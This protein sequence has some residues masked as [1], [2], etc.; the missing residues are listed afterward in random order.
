M[1]DFTVSIPPSLEVPEDFPSLGASSSV[2]GLSSLNINTQMPPIRKYSMS[3]L[4]AADSP[5]TPITPPPQY[6]PAQGDKSTEYHDD[7][8]GWS[9]LPR[10]N[11]IEPDYMDYLS[12]KVKYMLELKSVVCHVGYR[13]DSGHYRSY[14]ADTVSNNGQQLQEPNWLRHDDLD[15]SGRRVQLITRD[16]PEDMDMEADWARNGYILFYELQTIQC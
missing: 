1:D 13:L 11:K 15:P 8:R 2:H 14:V 10:E 16:S 4:Q 5:R 12:P 6:T 9:P 7:K 3:F